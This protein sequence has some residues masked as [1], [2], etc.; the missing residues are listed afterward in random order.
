MLF[1][2]RK[3]VEEKNLPFVSWLIAPERFSDHPGSPWYGAW[4][5]SKVMNILTKNPEV[6]K[7]TIFI[8]NYDEN[9]GY[10]D[11]VIP[12]TPPNDP[13]QQVDYNGEN[14]VDFLSKEQSYMKANQE[15][16]KDRLEGPIGLGYRVPLIVASPWSRGGYVNSEVFDHTSVIALIEDIIEKKYKKSVKTDLISHWRSS[17]CGNLTSIFQSSENTM[18]T[19]DFIDQKEFASQINAAK[20]KPVPE[21]GWILEEESSEELL[22]LLQERGTKKSNA[23]P[24]QLLVH[25]KDNAIVM[26]N[27]SSNGVPLQVFDRNALAKDKESYFPYAFYSKHTLVH[28]LEQEEVDMEV[29]GPNG[30]YRAF[31]GAS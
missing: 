17:I 4:Y 7:N 10:F 5:I 24:Y 12:F 8:I 13:S 15:K 20:D 26:E 29:L 19:L 9:D 22:E 1:Q 6:W 3:D 23:L 14:G 28:Q 2:F 30:L 31:K 18:P 21:F 16:E 25:L 27:L 11:H